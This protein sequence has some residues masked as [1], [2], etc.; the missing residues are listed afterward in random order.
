MKILSR[1]FITSLVLCATLWFVIA[2]FE[3]DS[4]P[5][6]IPVIA[7][8]ALTM[9]TLTRVRDLRLSP[10]HAVYFA[11]FF[12]WNS[13]SGGI[14]VARRALSPSLPVDPGFIEFR[15]R[16]SAESARVFFC[17]VVSQTPGTYVAD[18]TDDGLL[19]HA[20]N[21]SQSIEQNLRTLETRVARLF[22]VPLKGDGEA[23]EGSS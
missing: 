18:F 7:I 10:F 11:A 16:I 9:S 1:R 4:V 19:I 22:G 2:E 14:D 20:L 5:F 21:R 23:E 13:V 3:A 8:A 12:L 15:S 6:G 17:H